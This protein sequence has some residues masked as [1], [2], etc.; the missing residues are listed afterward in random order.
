MRKIGS[1]LTFSLLLVLLVAGVLSNFVLANPLIHTKPIMLKSQLSIRKMTYTMEVMFN[2]HLQ[3][4]PTVLY[5][6]ISNYSDSHCF[7]NLDS[8]S[9]EFKELHIV[10]QTSISNDNGY[11]PYTELTLTGNTTLTGYP[12]AC[13][14]LQSTLTAR[15]EIWTLH[16]P[17][18]SL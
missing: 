3:F 1:V 15:L 12:M 6:H 18:V 10:A 17:S 8:K 4:L 2:F 7:I 9:T 11:D 13:I 5:N 14:T 16:K